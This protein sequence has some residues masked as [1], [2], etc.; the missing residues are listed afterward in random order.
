[1]QLEDY[2]EFEKFETKHG[3]AERIRVRGTR[4]AIDIVVDEFNEG[5]TPDQIQKR[6]PSLTLEQVFAALT[7]YL[8][9]KAAVDEYLARGYAIEDAFYQEWLAN[10]SPAVQRLRAV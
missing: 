8:H 5:R 1:M 7:Y 9:N 3:A 2:F 6:Y 4:I 10:P